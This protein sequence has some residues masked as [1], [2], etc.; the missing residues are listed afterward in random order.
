MIIFKKGAS[1][2]E[3][4][5]YDKRVY[6]MENE[7]AWMTEEIFHSYMKWVAGKL[8]VIEGRKIFW[9]DGCQAHFSN[10][11]LTERLKEQFDIQLEAGIAKMTQF[12][13]P[14]DQYIIALFKQYIREEIYQKIQEQEEKLMRFIAECDSV[15]T[16]ERLDALKKEIQM[17]ISEFRIFLTGAVGNAWDKLLELEHIWIDSWIPSGLT[18]PVS[19]AKDKEWKHTMIEKYGGTSA[20]DESANEIDRFTLKMRAITHLYNE[21]KMQPAPVEAIVNDQQTPKGSSNDKDSIT[22]QE[23]QSLMQSFLESSNDECSESGDDDILD[24]SHI[25]NDN[26]PPPSNSIS[27]TISASSI[28]SSTSRGLVNNFNKCYQNSILQCWANSNCIINVFPAFFQLQFNQINNDQQFEWNDK[29]EITRTLYQILT[30]LRDNTFITSVDPKHLIN[31]LPTPWCGPRQQDATEFYAHLTATLKW[32]TEQS[33]TQ[34]LLLWDIIQFGIRS[35]QTCNHCNH[36]SVK[37]ETLCEI[38]V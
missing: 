32:L 15:P 36:K 28:C 31:L 35:Q 17:S 33:T 24:L 8:T 18:L 6:V 10:E 2:T 21:I 27:T 34:P 16:P 11:D 9:I 30:E 37:L 22:Q 4:E 38:Q 1:I 19:G 29:M 14:C 25:T 13:Q 3:K 26:V 12:W 5:K 20:M 7:K 23:Q